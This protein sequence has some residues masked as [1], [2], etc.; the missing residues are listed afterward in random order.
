[1]SKVSYSKM[2]IDFISEPKFCYGESNFFKM[3]VDL[4]STFFQ[5]LRT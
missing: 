3:A 1:M 2:S 4:L 5:I